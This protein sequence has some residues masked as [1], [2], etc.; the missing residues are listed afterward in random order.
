MSK[1]IIGIKQA[2]GTFY[3]ILTRGNPA[4]KRL[5]ITTAS[6]N[7]TVAQIKLFCAS[8]ESFSDAEYVDTLIIDGLIPQEKQAVIRLCC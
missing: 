4:K 8:D 1:N 2:D 5:Q 3:P 6:D 7:Q